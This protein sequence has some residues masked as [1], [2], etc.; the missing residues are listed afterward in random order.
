MY[1]N[2]NLVIHTLENIGMT[3]KPS[4]DVIM[5]PIAMILMILSVFAMQNMKISLRGRVCNHSTR[6][7]WLTVTEGGRLKAISLASG[8]CT[9]TSTQDAEAVWGSDCS[10]EPCQYQAWKVGAGRYDLRDAN[11]SGGSI[12]RIHGWGAGSSWHITREWPKPELSSIP[13]SLVK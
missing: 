10:A 8:Q 11:S 7:V 12:L 1:P 6:E 5:V 2:T 3:T 4:T 9:D 13:Y